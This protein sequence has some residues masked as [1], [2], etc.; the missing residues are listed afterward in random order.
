MHIFLEFMILHGHLYTKGMFGVHDRETRYDKII[1][2]CLNL[3]FGAP[4]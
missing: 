2:Y 1:I 4:I 3:L